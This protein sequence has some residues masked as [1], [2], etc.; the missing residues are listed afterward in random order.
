MEPNSFLDSAFQLA[1]DN[2]DKSFIGDE[3]VKKNLQL[4][5]SCPTKAPVRI[6]LTAMMVKLFKPEL[7]IRKPF[8]EPVK[9]KVKK[10]KGEIEIFSSEGIV[11]PDDSYSG[12]NYDESYVS[13]FIL[14]HKFEVTKTTG[15]LTPAFRTK[16]GILERDTELNGKHPAA[17]TAVLGLLNDVH[18]NVLKGGPILN[19]LVRLLIV[20]RDKNREAIS[21]KLEQLEL[22]ESDSFV[23]LSSENIVNLIKG[24]FDI[25]GAS[26][27]P[28]LLVTA[29]YNCIEGKLGEKVLPLN[30]HNA[31]D[32]QT[33]SLGD[34]EVTLR[35]DDEIVTVYEMK[36]K[37]VIDTDILGALTKLVGRKK[38]DNYI[39]ITTDVIDPIVQS[40]ARDLYTKYG[41][42]FVILDCIG[43]VRHFLHLFH[44]HRVDFL[45][46]YQKLILS[47][48]PN[49]VP[50]TQKELWLAAR[51]AAESR[52][53]EMYNQGQDEP[54]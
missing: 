13:N 7:D 46:A 22:V 17:Y 30:A 38:I 36:M 48:P 25:A 3:S 21:T 19:E 4:I 26:R 23:P 29:A 41:V 11:D 40:Q 37:R 33:G 16:N 54:E 32:S 6:L 1:K 8:K 12:R 9:K 51:L 52:N 47:E 43:F 53:N 10:K 45:N 18:D 20:Q 44:R 28:V 15:F 2:I 42:E 5:V 34:V 31:A 39:F 24:Q 14:N 50:Q 49:T 27:L 35:S